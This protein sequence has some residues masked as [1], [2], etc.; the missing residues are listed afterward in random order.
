MQSTPTEG[1]TGDLL[2]PAELIFLDYQAF[3][4]PLR[5]ATLAWQGAAEVTAGTFGFMAERFAE[6]Q[7]SLNGL[8]TCR[9]AS[10][11]EALQRSWLETAIRQYSAFGETLSRLSGEASDRLASELSDVWTIPAAD[12]SGDLA[13]LTRPAFPG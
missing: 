2:Q 4:I 13:A 1:L 11:A 3:H 7:K 6:D 8:A 9:D 10:A 5:L 12:E